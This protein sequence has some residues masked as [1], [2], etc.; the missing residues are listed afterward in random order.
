MHIDFSVQ[1]DCLNPEDSYGEICVHCNCCGRYDFDDWIEGHEELQRKNIQAN[2][3]YY[4][5]LIKQ[6]EIEDSKL[7]AQ[8][9]E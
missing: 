2:I 3:E 6:A 8:S 4:T 1:K 7:Q 9:K 5:K